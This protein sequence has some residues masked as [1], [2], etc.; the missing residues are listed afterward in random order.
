MPNHST[1]LSGLLPAEEAQTLCE[2]L[3]KR[4]KLPD[5]YLSNALGKFD[6]TV[7]TDLALRLVHN[8][9]TRPDE[10][11]KKRYISFDSLAEFVI[12]HYV[13]KCKHDLAVFAA[14]LRMS[15][16]SKFDSRKCYENLLYAV[17]SVSRLDRKREGQHFGK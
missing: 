16:L 1:N 9:H 14:T 2:T 13:T 15:G 3:L 10:T 11:D 12:G 4:F 8:G 17:S 5:D 6:K 7:K